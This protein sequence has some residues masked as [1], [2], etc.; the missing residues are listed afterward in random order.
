MMPQLYLLGR[1][2]FNRDYQRF[3]DAF[4]SSSP[5]AV[6][7]ESVGATPAEMLV[8]FAGRSCYMSFGSRQS[9]KTNAKYIENLIRNGHE[10][11]LEHAVWTIGITHVS[12]AFTHQFVRHRVG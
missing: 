6:W 12:R 11:V 9:D 2:L 10:S 7:R 8:E 1:P 5:N 4:F 3:L